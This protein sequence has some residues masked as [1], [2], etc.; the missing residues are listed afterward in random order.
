MR[1]SAELLG[2]SEQRTNPLGEREIVLRGLAI[3]AIEH[4]GVTRDAFDAM[5]FSDNRLGRL[6]NFPRLHRLSS[7]KLSGNVV[8]SVDSKNLSK[9]VP[10]LP[11]SIP[12]TCPRTF[13]T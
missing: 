7:L 10:N 9:N 12:K 2:S 5:D 4:L 8:T 1:L 3:P 11:P 6:D 13:Q